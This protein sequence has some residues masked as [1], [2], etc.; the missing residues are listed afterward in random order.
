[1]QGLSED[2][3]EIAAAYLSREGRMIIEKGLQ[4][5]GGNRILFDDVKTAAFIKQLEKEARG[6]D[7][8]ARIDEMIDLMKSEI[9]GRLAVNRW[10]TSAIAQRLSSTPRLLGPVRRHF[11]RR[12]AS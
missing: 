5:A 11:S 10:C 6:I 2:L 9:A 12:E 3:K 1:L 8:N 4:E 7:S